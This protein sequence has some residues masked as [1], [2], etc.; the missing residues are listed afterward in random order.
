MVAIITII[1]VWDNSPIDTSSTE[2]KNKISQSVSNY[3]LNHWDKC[4]HAAPA[5]TEGKYEVEFSI[6]L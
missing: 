3:I 6:T 1:K 2:I 5:I 4:V